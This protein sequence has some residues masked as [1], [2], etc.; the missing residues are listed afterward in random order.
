M[1]P[2]E[3]ER[4]G[5]REI[6]IVSFYDTLTHFETKFIDGKKDI[7]MVVFF[8]LACVGVCSETRSPYN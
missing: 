5:G 1:M 7:T 4:E 3:R 6:I 8:C 2:K